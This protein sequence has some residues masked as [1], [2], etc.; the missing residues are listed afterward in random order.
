MKIWAAR[1]SW[2]SKHAHEKAEELDKNKIKKIAVIKHAALGDM[3]Q[4]RP[5]LITLKEAFPNAEITL[6]VVSNYM[7]GIPEDL[8]D[9]LHIA[10]GNEKKYSIKECYKSYKSLGYHD[11]IFDIS[12]TARS[13]WVTKLNPAGLKI[14][15]MHKGIQRILYD[16]AIPRSYYRFEGETFLEQLNPIGLQYDW[17]LR[18]NYPLPE[19]IY[20][21]PYIVYF[22]TA[23]VADK[24]WPLDYMAELINKMCKKYPEIDHLLISGLADWEKESAHLIAAKVKGNTNLKEIAGGPDA[25]PLVCHAK[26]L[27]SSDT[28][29]RHL[30]IAA[31]TPTV[32]IF[33][34][35]P[36]IFSYSPLF[37]DHKTIVADES[38]PASV[39]KA[40]QAIH[41][42]MK[43]KT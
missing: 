19:N 41:E 11:L 23:S 34:I 13:F 17:P 36:H 5:M 18:Y 10:A 30:A 1:Q 14:G 3:L 9:N 35:S 38:G 12:A 25:F 4:V 26:V 7:K 27:V 8:I 29:L 21:K 40:E 20:D 24:C 43:N 22:P 31:E 15:Y 42:I 39:E 33:P 28:G 16:V 6:G 2:V 37:G 32:G